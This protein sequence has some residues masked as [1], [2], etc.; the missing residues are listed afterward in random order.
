[1]AQY[2]SP[3]PF[4]RLELNQYQGNVLAWSAGV[5]FSEPTCAHERWALMRRLASV[6]LSAQVT[7]KKVH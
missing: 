7:R 5:W 3:C 2:S 4:H 1:M 6:R